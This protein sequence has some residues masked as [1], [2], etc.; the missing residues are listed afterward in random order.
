MC[1]KPFQ[2]HPEALAIAGVPSVNLIISKPAVLS[3]KRPPPP[4][5]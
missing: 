4:P 1:D 5:P 3:G 2:T